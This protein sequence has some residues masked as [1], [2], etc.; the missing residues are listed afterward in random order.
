MAVQDYGT[1]QARIFGGQDVDPEDWPEQS[2][3]VP[4]ESRSDGPQENGRKLVICSICGYLVPRSGV[5]WKD[6][7]PYCI[8]NGCSKD[9]DPVPRS[10]AAR[11]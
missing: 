9:L 5:R 8:A 4:L 7:K 6:G 10:E 3:D 2:V 11:G 1:E